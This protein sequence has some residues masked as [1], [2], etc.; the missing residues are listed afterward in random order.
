VFSVGQHRVFYQ[1]TDAAGNTANCSFLV[2]VEA[3]AAASSVLGGAAVSGVIAGVSALLLL[4]VV[5]AVVVRH[6]VQR[7]RKP[8][9]WE[10]I[11]KLIDQFRNSEEGTVRVPQ[12]LNRAWVK[13]LEQLGRGAF[14][15]GP[16]L[17]SFLALTQNQ[18]GGSAGWWDELKVLVRR[19]GLQGSPGAA[20]NATVLGGVQESS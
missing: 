18:D 3:A 4:V 8:A 17:L 14:G 7:H 13:L 9:S 2:A 10:E 15:T 11:F 1:A 16:L 20:R 6:Q 5:L 12:E 19:A